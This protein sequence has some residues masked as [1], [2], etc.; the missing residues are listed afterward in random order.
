MA[1]RIHNCLPR[2]LDMLSAPV[3]SVERVQSTACKAA[4]SALI[5]LRDGYYDNAHNLCE[6]MRIYLYQST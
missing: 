2:A 3:E 4:G 5:P 1:I 6:A